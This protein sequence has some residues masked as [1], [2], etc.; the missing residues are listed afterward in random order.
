MD[1]RPTGQPPAEHGGR[2]R[3]Q[4]PRPIKAPGFWSSF[5]SDPRE[6]S[7]VLFAGWGAIG[8]GTETALSGSAGA[9][10]RLV[11]AAT[12]AGGTVMLLSYFLYFKPGSLAT[13]AWQ[14][15]PSQRRA[16]LVIRH[17]WLGVFT[18]WV[19]VWLANWIVAR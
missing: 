3:G 13:S 11:G 6:L 19:A 12:A 16:V 10:T 2:H 18:I 8:W 1:Q 7:F 4:S 17:L 14:R 9:V 15:V 5:R